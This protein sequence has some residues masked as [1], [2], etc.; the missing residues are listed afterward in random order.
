MIAKKYRVNSS[1]INYVMKK[2]ISLSSGLFLVK[3]K[4]NTEQFSR[5]SVI[6][7]KKVAKEAVVRNLLRRRA[8]ES[9]RL[10]IPNEAGKNEHHFDI[11][12]IAK[13]HVQA[14]NYSS[15][16]TDLTKIQLTLLSDVQ[17]Q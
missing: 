13:K 17:K 6:I 7:S 12:L 8:Y 4:K 2:G 9:L 15:L 10:N 16:N 3:L 11:V 1:Q 5:Y 14:S